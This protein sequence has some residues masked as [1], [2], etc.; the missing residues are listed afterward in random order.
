M[1]KANDDFL[2]ALDDPNAA[3]YG[4]DRTNVTRDHSKDIDA[5]IGVLDQQRSHNEDNRVLDPIM[6]HA[7]PPPV[8]YDPVV[9]EQVNISQE[10]DAITQGIIGNILTAPKDGMSIDEYNYYKSLANSGKDKFYD[11]GNAMEEITAGIQQDLNNNNNADAVASLEADIASTIGVMDEAVQAG[12]LPNYDY[13]PTE[14]E[15]LEEVPEEATS[16][17]EGKE[18]LGTLDDS[19]EVVST[20]DTE[21][22]YTPMTE[23]EFEDVPVTNLDVDTEVVRNKVSAIDGMT[24]EDAA[25]VLDVMR[26]YKAG[27]KFNVFQALPQILKTQISKSAIEVGNCTPSGLNFFA[28]VFINDLVSDAYITN[29]IN[30]FQAQLNEYT[31]AIGNINGLVVDSYSDELKQKLEDHLY[32]VADKIQEENPEKA[33]ELRDIA[34]SFNAT[35]TLSRIF[36]PI[37]TK[38][39]TYLNKV[40]KATRKMSRYY[41]EFNQ[42]FGNSKPKIRDPRTVRAAIV[43]MLGNYPN[44][45]IVDM[46]MYML[47][48][49]CTELP[50]GTLSTNIYTFYL[51]TGIFNT[52]ITANTADTLKILKGNMGMLIASMRDYLEVRA[53]DPRYNT[54]KERRRQKKLQEKR[55]R[56]QA[57]R[58]G[59]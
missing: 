9:A 10:M 51:M 12:I 38:G 41:E 35:Y 32:E 28:K 31:D 22:D 39:D 29:E 34:K 42:E 55:A 20:E 57:Y 24:S 47:I 11:G 19:C 48:S 16:F 27:E 56:Q 52:I 44:D 13:N 49:S 2:L 6:M 25:V 45:D 37:A 30:D 53:N 8:G 4:V 7:T 1:S 23:E 18:Q 5:I 54:K 43:R 36:E 50:K 14:H 59:R 17:P 3:S 33:E 26:R 46:I 15:I 40:Y 21:E 58:R